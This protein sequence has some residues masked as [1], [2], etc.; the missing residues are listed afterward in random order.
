MAVVTSDLRP[1]F[2]ELSG[3]VL[4]APADIQRVSSAALAYVGD[5]VYELFI[6]T[7]CLLPPSRLRDYHQQV[8]A[9]VRAEAQAECLRSLLP[10]LTPPELEIVR[11]GR[12]AAS[13]GPKRVNPELYQLATGLEALLGFLYLTDPSRLGQIFQ[14]L[15]SLLIATSNQPSSKLD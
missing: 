5:A 6:R 2:L 1:S 7:R 9:C 15:E 12:N 4:P 3:G 10:Y 14:L 11:Q 8:V 13:A